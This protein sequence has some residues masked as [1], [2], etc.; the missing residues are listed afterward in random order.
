MAAQ[1]LV[2]VHGAGA[3]PPAPALKHELDLLLFGRDM[4]TTRVANYSDVRWP[5]TAGGTRTIGPGG[6]R[7]ARRSR[8][9][10]A[11]T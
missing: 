4:A 11:A 2:Y 3:Q 9:I 5:P 8:A 7:R 1:R 10:G 6:S